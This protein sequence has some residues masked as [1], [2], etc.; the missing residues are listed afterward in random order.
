MH[1]ALTLVSLLLQVD[2]Q[3]LKWGADSQGGAPYVFENPKHPSDIIGFEVEVMQALAQEL[4]RPAQLV[5]GPYEKLLDLLERGDFELVLNGIENT[6]EKAKFVAL[7]IPYFVAPLTL[8]TRKNDA[9]APHTAS[10]LKG[11]TVGT[12]PSTQAERVAHDLGAVVKVYEGGQDDI[13]TDLRLER[14]DA[15]LLDAPIATYYGDINE[16]FESTSNTFP[17]TQYSV[18]LRLADSAQLQMVNV[19][20]ERLKIN[21]TLES[22]YRRW[23]VWNKETAELFQTEFSKETNPV[24]LKEWNE[25]AAHHI[26]MYE[27][28]FVS[29]PALFPSLLKGAGLTLVVSLLAFLMASLLGTVLAMAR[30][31]GPLWLSNLSLMYV[32]FF[33]GTPLLIQLTMLYFGLPELGIKLPPLAAGILALGLNYAASEAENQRS[34]F[35]SVPQGQ[36]EA[37]QVLGFSWWQTFSQIVFPQALR[38]ALPPM[39]NDFIALLKD[40]SLVSLV[41]LTE[42]TRSYT[43]LANATRDHLGLGLLVALMYLAMGLPV[44]KLARHLEA[45]FSSHLSRGA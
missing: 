23:G 21:R 4:K 30:S 3:P 8:T 38:T 22:I 29:Y 24:R 6:P 34:G 13:Y 2:S 17:V 10:Q 40:S 37:A 26:G 28:I 41:T 14:L 18:A 7:S 44:A 33:R 36:W 20:L 25:T 35:Q 45:K 1:T 12:L 9:Q 32:E 16:A 27:R 31:F 42:L 39:T 5:T 19:A 11:K 15:V 43:S